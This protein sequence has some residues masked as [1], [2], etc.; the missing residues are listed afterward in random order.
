MAPHKWVNY[1]EKS[2]T[3]HKTIYGLTVGLSALQKKSVYK[4]LSG[5]QV[6]CYGKAHFPRI[7][8][9]FMPNFKKKPKN[10]V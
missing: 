8:P 2:E 4:L 1:R 5:R 7:L 6:C 10:L 3:A 9:H